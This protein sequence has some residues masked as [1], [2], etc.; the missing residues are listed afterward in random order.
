MDNTHFPHEP[1]HVDN[2]VATVAEVA[3]GNTCGIC[4]AASAS[5]RNSDT[6]GRAWRVWIQFY[7]FCIHLPIIRKIYVSSRSCK[8]TFET[9]CVYVFVVI[10]TLFHEVRNEC[11]FNVTIG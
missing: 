4:H 7:V 6:S 10:N 1:E 9:P 3:P 2:L 5:Q 11:C 8:A